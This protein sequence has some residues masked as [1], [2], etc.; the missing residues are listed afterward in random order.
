MPTVFEKEYNYDLLENI[1]V[2]KKYTSDNLRWKLLSL[3]IDWV[4]STPDESVFWEVS[5]SSL[6][7]DAIAELVYLTSMWINITINSYW[8]SNAK[9]YWELLYIFNKFRLV[10]NLKSPVPFVSQ[11]LKWKNLLTYLWHNKISPKDVVC[12]DDEYSGYKALI[13]FWNFI[14]VDP[15]VWLTSMVREQVEKLFI[16]NNKKFI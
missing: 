14:K 6:S 9:S 10:D 7:Y 13:D 8:S 3:D 15:M 16:D 4:I 1:T 11:S 12:L 5:T 2:P